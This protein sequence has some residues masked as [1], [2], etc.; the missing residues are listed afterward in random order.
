MEKSRKIVLFP[1][2]QFYAVVGT[3]TMAADPY[4]LTITDICNDMSSATHGARNH[5]HRPGKIYLTAAEFYALNDNTR[6]VCQA[7]SSVH[8]ALKDIR[9]A[10]DFFP[11]RHKGNQFKRREYGERRVVKGPFRF[12]LHAHVISGV[13]DQ[14]EVYRRSEQFLGLTE[15][16][17]EELPEPEGLS[18]PGFLEMICCPLP[19][20]M[21]VNL[22]NVFHS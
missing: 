12:A 7:M 2:G 17:V 21:A 15:V 8:L 13:A 1:V 3:I 14:Q 10:I 5:L 9:A 16:A 4:S 11:E 20:Y 18:L 19:D 22:A 6:K